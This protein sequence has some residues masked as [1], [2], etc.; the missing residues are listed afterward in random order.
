MLTV[1]RLGIFLGL[2]SVLRGKIKFSQ[3][4]NLLDPQLLTDKHQ[5]VN[6]LRSL[7]RQFRMPILRL[8]RL[9]SWLLKL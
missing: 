8:E 1:F 6:E 9:F 4:T 2:V 3:Y 5:P 7:L